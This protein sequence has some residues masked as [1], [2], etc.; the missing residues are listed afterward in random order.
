MIWQKLRS[1]LRDHGIKQIWLA[2][3]TGITKSKLSTI[4]TGQSSL[5]VDDF[6]IICSAL[7]TSSET[8]MNYPLPETKSS[9]VHDETL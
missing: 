5:N 9:E 3:K 4:L 6:A 2:E 8:I 1:Y 7:N